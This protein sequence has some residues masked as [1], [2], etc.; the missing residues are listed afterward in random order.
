MLKQARDCKDPI[1]Q[2][3]ATESIRTSA[4]ALYRSLKRSVTHPDARV[5]VMSTADRNPFEAWRQL[6]QKYDPRNDASAM[7]LIDSILDKSKWKCA[8]LTDILVKLA[9]WEALIR[10]HSQRTGEEAVNMASKRQLF[11]NMLPDDVRRFLE[12]QTMFKPGLTFDVIKAV[13][14]DMVQRVTDMPTPMDTSPLDALKSPEAVAPVDAFGRQAP[15]TKPGKGEGKGNNGNGKGTDDKAK[16]TRTCHN[17][18]R[19]GHIAKDCWRPK[20]AKG[21]GKGADQVGRRERG[22]DG[23]WYRRTVNSWELEEDQQ[24]GAWAAAEDH[25]SCGS[26][27]IVG[28]LGAGLSDEHIGIHSFEEVPPDCEGFGDVCAVDAVEQM[29]GLGPDY[30]AADLANK[31]V[32]FMRNNAMEAKI[33]AVEDSDEDEAGSDPMSGGNDAWTTHLALS[34]ERRVHCGGATQC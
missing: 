31:F 26:L 18:D 33:A 7:Q 5:I 22:N 23:R 28:G 9:K 2:L 6:F 8:R 24:D 19:P 3:G 20:K 29:V 16:E 10:E 25:P 12:V 30:D 4:R 27:D 32:E 34:A 21:A 17:C 14:M 11:K 13:V 15:G 1:T